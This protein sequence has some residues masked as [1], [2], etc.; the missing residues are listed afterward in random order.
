[1][2]ISD[3]SSDVCSSDLHDAAGRRLDPG[4]LP[5]A[6]PDGLRD[7]TAQRRDGLGGADAVE[8]PDARR[9]RERHRSELGDRRTD[10][11]PD[12]SEERSVGKKWVRTGESRWAPD[13]Q[14][15]NKKEQAAS[16]N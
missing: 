4:A 13:Q 8:A 12:R 11:L 2:R 10:Q 7:R 14:I 5:R 16:E 9:L 6:R 3:W 15:K 1:M